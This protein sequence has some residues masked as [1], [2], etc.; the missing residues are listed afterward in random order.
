MP[1]LP[2]QYSED[3]GNTWRDVTTDTV[4][5]RD[6]KLQTLYVSPGVDLGE[7]PRGLIPTFLKFLNFE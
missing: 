7:G 4:I 3:D 2:V 6:V 5:E 1:G